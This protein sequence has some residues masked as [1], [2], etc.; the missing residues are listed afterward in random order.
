MADTPW[1]GLAGWLIAK[2][3]NR[4]LHT[5]QLL[6]LERVALAPRQSLVLVETEGRRLLVATSADSAPAF[7]PLNAAASRRQNAT[8]R[9][10]VK[11]AS[12]RS[13]RVSW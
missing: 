6:V 3:R 13:G 9:R 2:L 7:F 11:H 1:S 12:A 8:A 4:S 5:P 10:S